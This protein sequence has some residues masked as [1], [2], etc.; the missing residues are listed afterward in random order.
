[1]LT[2]DELLMV[3]EC[4]WLKHFT[5]ALYYFITGI[6]IHQL[7][8]TTPQYSLY[9]IMYK[10]N[11]ILQSRSF[12]VLLIEN[13]CTILALLLCPHK[14]WVVSWVCQCPSGCPT[15]FPFRVLVYIISQQCLDRVSST[16]H[17]RYTT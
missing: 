2:V 11:N 4:T 9:P 16:S 3:S 17:H 15:G 8:I 10:N 7:I 5:L 1:M 12:L 13:V 6:L 14:A